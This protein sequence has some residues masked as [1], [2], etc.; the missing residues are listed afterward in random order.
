MRARP[1]VVAEPE[2]RTQRCRDCFHCKVIRPFT[3]AVPWGAPA[4]SNLF[5][6]KN[7]EVRCAKGV[8]RHPKGSKL[9]VPLSELTRRVFSRFA[10]M[11]SEWEYMPTAEEEADE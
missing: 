8:W 4:P 5:L 7:P 10:Q 11:C 1:S 9:A 2:Q 3:N 6:S